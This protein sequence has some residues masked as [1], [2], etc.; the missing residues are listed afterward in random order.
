MN[1]PLAVSTQQIV[2]ATNCPGSLSP[3]D[4]R[5]KE[6][7]G[8]DDYVSMQLHVSEVSVYDGVKHTRS[9]RFPQIAVETVP[10]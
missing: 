1:D 3:H 4:E 9:E 2:L 6:L 10:G 8:H 7:A 5:R